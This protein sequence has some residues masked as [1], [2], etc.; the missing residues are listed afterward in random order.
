MDRQKIIEMANDAAEAELCHRHGI[1]DEIELMY[2]DTANSYVFYE[3]YQDEYMMLVDEF[4]E[5]LSN[6]VPMDIQTIQEESHKNSKKSGFWD[7]NESFAEKTALIHS[8]LSEALEADRKGLYDDKLPDRDGREVELADAI[9][10]I[11]DLAE[12]YGFDL[13]TAINEKMVYNA[14]RGY[15]HGAKY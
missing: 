13:D 11:C 4:E 8:E 15:K 6:N 5:Q 14:G 9:I 1:S 2:E 10:R 12:A 3:K 7:D